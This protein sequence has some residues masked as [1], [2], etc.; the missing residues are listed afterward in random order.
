MLLFLYLFGSSLFTIVS[1]RSLYRDFDIT[2]GDSR[3]KI[4]NSGQLLTLSLDKTSGSGFQSRHQYL[5]GKIDMQIKLVA[6]DSAGTVT[7][8]YLSSQ[9]PTHDEIDFEFLGNLS[10]DPYTLHT[11]VFTQG[12]GNREMQFRLWFDP[13]RDFHTYSVLWNSRH[14]MS[15]FTN[16]FPNAMVYGTLCH[17]LKKI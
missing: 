12:K 5:F 6:G 11:N 9:G 1:S 7:A 4:L 14:I 17:V 2:W 15:V 8:Y 10:G 3:A 13:T 16:F